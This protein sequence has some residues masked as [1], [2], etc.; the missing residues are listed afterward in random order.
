[1]AV[2]LGA[3]SLGTHQDV[4]KARDHQEDYVNALEEAG[5]LLLLVCDGMGGHAAGDVASRRAGLILAQH[6]HVACLEQDSDV[7]LSLWSALVEANDVIK[8]EATAPGKA[9]MGTTAVVA[10]LKDAAVWVAHVGDSRLLHLRGGDVVFRTKDH[11]RVQKMIDAG[12]LTPEQAASHQDANV[13]LRALGHLP[14]GGTDPEKQPEVQG[15]ALHVEPGDAIL[16]CS[17]GL[18]D[19]VS[20]AEVCAT[21]GGKT[22]ELAARALVDLA[23]DRGGTDNI[24]VAIGYYG[25]ETAPW[26]APARRHTLPEAPAPP[27]ELAPVVAPSPVAEGAAAHVPSSPAPPWKLIAIAASVVS[28]L[29]LVALALVVL[30]FTERKPSATPPSPPSASAVSAAVIRSTAA[31]S[32]T[33]PSASST[34]GVPSASS[35]PA[36]S[37][38]PSV[39]PA[40][41]SS[42]RARKGKR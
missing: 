5:Q 13:V 30:R 4:G 22:P 39:P 15:D 1:M 2:R 32:P 25:C 37:A 8:T 10:W 29:A 20:D 12:I 19:L 28:T 33:A 26:A 31:N 36:A 16:L 34:S 35:A 7:R 9:G 6:F 14:E 38:A 40:P 23:N 41:S 27:R 17:D 18:Y 11:T 24:S 42:N 3:W 21:L